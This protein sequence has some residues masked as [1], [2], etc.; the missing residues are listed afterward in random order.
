MSQTNENYRAYLNHFD[1][2][3]AAQ[4]AAAA[5][6]APIAKGLEHQDA[7]AAGTMAAAV[8]AALL[9]HFR[10]QFCEDA[11]RAQAS[12]AYGT[13]R[14]RKIGGEIAD[15]NWRIRSLRGRTFARMTQLPEFE[16]KLAK[17]F[18][19]S[20]MKVDRPKALV[21]EVRDTIKGSALAG[22]TPALGKAIMAGLMSGWRPILKPEEKHPEPM[23]QVSLP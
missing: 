16:E 3:A 6:D 19:I 2:E 22:E 18:S 5:L 7:P 17:A 23:L 8:S 11:M 15:T 14:A 20:G 12:E 9:E 10:D 1:V 21:N 4:R 13:G